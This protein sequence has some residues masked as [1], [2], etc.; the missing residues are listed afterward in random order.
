MKSYRKD[1]TP[2]ERRA[3]R[4]KKKLMRR[5]QVYIELGLIAFVV[6]AI[7]FL[8][9]TKTTGKSI[10][11][12]SNKTEK[13][14][15][16]TTEKEEKSGLKVGA[17]ASQNDSSAEEDTTA[18][19]ET[20]TSAYSAKDAASVAE[21]SSDVVSEYGILINNDTKEVIAG[22]NA[23]EKIIPAS[24]TKV[25]TVLVAANNITADQLDDKVTL[26][27]EAVDYSYAG[28]GS[29][30]G[31][32]EGEEVTVKDLF[33]GTILPS[34]GDAAAQLAMYVAGDIDTFVGMMNDELKTLGLSDTSHFTNPVGFYADDHYST[35][36]DI[37]IIMMAAMDNDIC[38]EVLNTKV[39]YSTATNINP[40]GIIISNWF[41]R[42]IEDKDIGGTIGGAKT[43]YVDES[44]SCAV[45]TMTTEAGVEYICCTAKSSSSWQ[46]INDH[47]T[48]YNNYVN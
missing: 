45:S 11:L 5:I 44:G 12:A 17:K 36:Y 43:G 10:S 37:A 9:Y 34:G 48:I 14:D 22:K 47:A 27:H 21:I 18:E 25:M 33:Y 24:M 28:G 32:V 15:A 16:V 23:H 38:N 42:R 8:V 41:L 19:E 46:C 31:F 29:T 30:S 26:S 6:F 7:S 40:E 4:K 20:V 13:T 1:M 35:P 3:Y 39:Y 2:E